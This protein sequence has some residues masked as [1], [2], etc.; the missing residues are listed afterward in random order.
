MVQKTITINFFEAQSA[1]ERTSIILNRMTDEKAENVLSA[2]LNKKGYPD[3]EYG[4]DEDLRFAES[5]TI[6][7]ETNG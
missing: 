6:K 1:E 7:F 2:M 3:I 4:Y 5:I